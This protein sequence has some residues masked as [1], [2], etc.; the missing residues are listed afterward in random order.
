[1]TPQHWIHDDGTTLDSVAGSDLVCMVDSGV[2]CR[3]HGTVDSVV[4]CGLDGTV[5]S[6]VVCGLDGTVDSVVVCG[7]DGT[8]DSVVVC[9][10]DGGQRWS[11]GTVRWSAAWSVG[12]M[13]A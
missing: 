10:L 7:L 5:D 6:V 4:V 13:S 3:L 1:M 12:W 11:A 2:V 8:V 9:G